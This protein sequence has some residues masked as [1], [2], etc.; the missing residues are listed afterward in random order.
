MNGL[1]IDDIKALQEAYRKDFGQEISVEEA[2]VLGSQLISLLR[3]VYIP[4]N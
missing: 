2:E 3:I 1:S 4:K